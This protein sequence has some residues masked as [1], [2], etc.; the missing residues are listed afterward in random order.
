MILF[1]TCKTGETCK[2]KI[3]WV[4]AKQDL[5]VSGKKKA[6]RFVGKQDEV[7]IGKPR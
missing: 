2:N 6:Y 7:I 3:N 4:V 1:L 5:P